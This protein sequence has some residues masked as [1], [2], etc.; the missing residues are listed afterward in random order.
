LL[1]GESTRGRTDTP[2]ELLTPAYL[3]LAEAEIARAIELHAAHAI[4]ALAEAGGPASNPFPATLR[5]L[6]G[7]LT[8]RRS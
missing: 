5:S 7:S 1:I 6:T 4:D 2:L 8:T 3:P